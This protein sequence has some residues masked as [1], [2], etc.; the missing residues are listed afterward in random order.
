MDWSRNYPANALVEA[1][2]AWLRAFGG[3]VTIFNSL[4]VDAVVERYKDVNI[5]VFKC[6]E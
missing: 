3:G 4:A 5:L 6:I 2:A 1:H